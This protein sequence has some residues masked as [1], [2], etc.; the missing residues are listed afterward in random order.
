MLDFVPSVVPAVEW[1]MLDAGGVSHAQARQYVVSAFKNLFGREP[2]LT[3]AQFAQAV[4]FIETVY[5]TTWHDAGVGSNNIG[6]VQTSLPP[7]GPD[8]FLYQ[9]SRPTAKGQVKYAVCFKK[10]PTPEAGWEGLL[11]EA[12]KKRPSAMAAASNGDLRAFSTALYNTHYYGGFGSTREER[13]EGHVQGLAAITKQIA[14]ALKEPAPVLRSRGG[15]S[16]ALSTGV[17]IVGMGALGW[18][19]YKHA[20]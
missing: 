9:D 1:W 15:A 16:S 17:V 5:G 20:A 7:C 13:I 11:L 10:Y 14:K 18:W 6:A 8:S 19:L 4:G 3:E 12:Y 2:S